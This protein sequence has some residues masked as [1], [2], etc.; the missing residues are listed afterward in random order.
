MV[1]RGQTSIVSGGLLARFEQR[2]A[3]FAGTSHAVALNNGTAALYVALWA[4]GVRAGDDVLICD[5]GFH[6]MAAAVLSLGARMVICDCDPGTLSI[7]PAEIQRKRTSRT[8]A[9]LVHSPW[10]VPAHFD[11]IR[12]AAGTLPIVSDASHAHGASFRG[13][14][15]AAWAD[16][17]CFSLGRLKLVSGGELGSAVTDHAELRDRIVLFGHVNR[18]PQGLQSLSWTGNAI[19]LKFRPHPAALSLALSQLAR[20]DEKLRLSRATCLRLEEMCAAH[21]ILPQTVPEGSQ[22]S[23]WKLVLHLGSTWSRAASDVVE[24]RLRSEGIPVEPN[25]Y[26]PLLQ[27][28]PL[29]DWPDYQ[30]LVTRCETRVAHAVTPRTITLPAPVSLE[31]SAFARTEE[32]LSKVAAGLRIAP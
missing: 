10:G 19:G 29:C 6:G 11:R 18:V 13:K 17:T 31:E 15:I 28:Q 25:H 26:W 3:A 8:K 5:Y 21:D 7:D 9:V 20:I 4:V 24:R 23:Y 14:P 22:R 2:F 30:Q 1:M 16:I 27:D 32:A 12:E